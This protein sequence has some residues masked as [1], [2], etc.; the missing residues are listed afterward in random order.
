[1]TR[2]FET[3]RQTVRREIHHLRSV[4][5]YVDVLLSTRPRVLRRIQTVLD[6]YQI[7]YTRYSEACGRTA[8][9]TAA[10]A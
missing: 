7:V 5:H 10:V 3:H 4:R 8:A 1:V 9:L 6:A 2:A